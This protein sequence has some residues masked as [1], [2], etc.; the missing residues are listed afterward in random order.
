MFDI[1]KFI[2]ISVLIIHVIR[3]LMIQIST[4]K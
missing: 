2:S 3:V 1:N 4:I